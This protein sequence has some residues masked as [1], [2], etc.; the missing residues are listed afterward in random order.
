MA[1]LMCLASHGDS[2][3]SAGH[4]SDDRCNLPT[5]RRENFS[6]DCG[7]ADEFYSKGKH[8]DDIDLLRQVALGT[9]Q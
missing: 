3:G 7:A 1:D 8:V 2:A 5:P 6:V 4:L 9:L